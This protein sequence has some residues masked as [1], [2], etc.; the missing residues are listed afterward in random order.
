MAPYPNQTSLGVLG[1]IPIYHSSPSV[2]AT[3]WRT[4]PTQGF[5]LQ[6]C[7]Y[8]IL[9]PLFIYLFISVKYILET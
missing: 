5:K 6:T 4:Y 2:A 3:Q 1:Q 8:S 7:N 9:L